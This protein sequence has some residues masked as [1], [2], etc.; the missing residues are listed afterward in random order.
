MNWFTKKEKTMYNPYQQMEF[1]H[2][3]CHGC[4]SQQK[5]GIVR[6]AACFYFDLDKSKPVLN[7]ERIEEERR[8]Q[9]RKNIIRRMFAETPDKVKKGWNIP[10]ANSEDKTVMGTCTM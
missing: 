3:G 5:Y 8:E 7:D 1:F 10:N 2:G 9:A 4:H 6:C